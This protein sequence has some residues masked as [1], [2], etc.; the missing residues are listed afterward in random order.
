MAVIARSFQITRRRSSYAR[1]RWAARDVGV[2]CV[3]VS[4]LIGVTFA[5]N[6]LMS[7][8][9]HVEPGDHRM[10]DAVT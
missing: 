5:I 6:L 9:S 2:I 7:K 1:R 10:T 3:R 4:T 8:W